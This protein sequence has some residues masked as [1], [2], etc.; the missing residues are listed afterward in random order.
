MPEE[1]EEEEEEEQKEPKLKL[2]VKDWVMISVVPLYT[3]NRILRSLIAFLAFIYH[4]A[5]FL[6]LVILISFTEGETR[7]STAAVNMVAYVTGF[8][9]LWCT[10]E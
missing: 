10:F 3:L 7:C 2:T 4:F 8:K 1:K 5:I 9:F 6:A